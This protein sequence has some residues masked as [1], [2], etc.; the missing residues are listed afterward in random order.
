MSADVLPDCPHRDAGSVPEREPVRE[1]T[2]K[3]THG[4]GALTHALNLPASVT[5]PLLFFPGNKQVIDML[6]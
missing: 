2:G 6:R 5:R 3:K 4:A 1:R